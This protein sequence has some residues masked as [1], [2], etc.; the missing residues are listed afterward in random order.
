MKK[1]GLVLLVIAGLFSCK[2]KNVPDVS[3]IKIDIT[4]KRFEQDFF[5]IDTNH[6][7]ASLQQLSEKY[8]LF[9]G[10]FLYNIMELPGISDTSSQEQALLKKFIA[11]YRPVKDSADEVFRNF[12]SIEKDVEKGLQFVKY[13]FPAYKTPPQLITYIGPMEG[14]SDVITRDALAVG[15]QLHM[16]KNYSLYRSSMGQSV[17]PDYISRRFTPDFITV[18]CM[19]NIINDIAPEKSGSKALIEQMVDKGKRLYVLDKILPYTADTVKTGYTGAQLQGCYENEGKIWNFFLTNS[20]LFSIDPVNIKT[21]MEEAPSTPELGDR[22]PGAIGVFVGWQIVKKY[23][24]KH[25][26]LSLNEL[27]NTDPKKIFEES[28]YRPG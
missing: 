3:D 6:I 8:P 24:S 11:D 12:N 26:G 14:Y 10:D 21:Y 18:N 1:A 25:E 28:K 13:Y 17:F 15:L 7:M 27:L 9:L 20:L 23:M 16:G 22:S 4:V 2:D 5:A 19:K